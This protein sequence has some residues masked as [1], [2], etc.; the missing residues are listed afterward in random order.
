MKSKREPS[1][2]QESFAPFPQF[3]LYV[4]SPVNPAFTQEM[5]ALESCCCGLAAGERTWPSISPNRLTAEALLCPHACCVPV[6]LVGTHTHTHYNENTTPA[7]TRKGSF[8]NVF[9]SL[10]SFSFPFNLK[11]GQH[12]E[13]LQRQA[14]RNNSLQQ[15][16]F[17]LV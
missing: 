14:T 8:L 5:F 6:S 15:F 16:P 11:V 1:N 17:P 10:L 2:K 3:H 12:S 4:W 7:S 9:F 13:G